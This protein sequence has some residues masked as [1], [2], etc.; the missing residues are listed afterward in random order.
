MITSSVAFSTVRFV[1][2]SGAGIQDG[3]SWANAYPGTSLQAAVNASSSGDHVWV[4]A[5]TYQTTS[6]TDRTISF[7]MKEGVLIYGSFA[8]T[9]SLLSQ[10]TMANGPT[11]ILTGEIGEAGISD[12]SYRVIINGDLTTASVLDGFVIRD[13]NDDRT[14]SATEGLGGGIYN[15]GSESGNSSPTIRNCVIT[16]NRATFGAGIFNNGFN[17]K[18][19]SPVISHCIITGNTAT[20]AG[21][22]IDNFGVTGNANPTIT[23]CLI[24]NNTAPKAGGMYNWGGNNGN[25]NPTILN[26]AFI[27]NSATDSAAGGLIADNLNQ[28]GGNSG[29]STVVVRNSIFWGNTATGGGPQFAIAGT[30]TFTS[31]YS[32]IDMSGQS[33]PHV[34]SGAGTGNLTSDPLFVNIS[35]GIGADDQW[36][37]SDD[38]LRLQSSSP[39]V[40]AG[41]NSGVPTV[42]LINNN[43]IANSIVDIGPYEYG[44]TP[45]PVELVSFSAMVQ[46]VKIILTWNTASE[47]NNHGFEVERKTAYS[48]WSRIGF[49]EGHG[50]SN[51]HHEY[52]FVDRTVPAGTIA[53]RL[54]QI[55]RDG[56]FSLSHTVELTSDASFSNFELSQNYPNPFNPSTSIRYTIPKGAG[57]VRTE[58]MVFDLL[59][60]EMEILVNEVQNAGVYHVRFNASS[61]SS[62][63]YL[64]RLRSGSFEE[65]RPMILMK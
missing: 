62:G 52:A 24:Y 32:I 23:N 39:G 57:G 51:I 58:L 31:T 4:A 47:T 16:N 54:K 40:D 61:F 56:T 38:G 21:G 14:A 13:G 35:N 65:I 22:G 5:G 64:Y 44:S 18:T 60:R 7:S 55:D 11:S 34:I 2:P 59:G 6:G 3:S 8:G 29:S 46:G 20:S 48:Q 45:L 25:A 26:S 42:D 30:G 17:G 50:S 15:A 53:Y 27:N 33:S 9:E 63:M 12:N 1:T 49:V 19:S 43:R 28:Y 36:M 10:R 41:V 37:T